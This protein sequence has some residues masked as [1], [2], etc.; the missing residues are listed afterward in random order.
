MKKY[1]FLNAT[2]TINILRGTVYKLLYCRWLTPL[3]F[4]FISSFALIYPK[5]LQWRMWRK[6]LLPLF[7]SF[8]I[9]HAKTGI[10]YATSQFKIA[11]YCLIATQTST[12]GKQVN[13]FNLKNNRNIKLS[14]IVGR[15]PFFKQCVR[16]P[17]SDLKGK[18]VAT[19]VIMYHC[20]LILW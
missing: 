6:E 8:S 7:I 1:L 2:K 12:N 9:P 19:T 5:E 13:K 10:T 4:P 20:L 3:P 14:S 16:L 15:S 17:E 11:A 18:A